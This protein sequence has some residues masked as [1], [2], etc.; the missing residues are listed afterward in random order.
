VA[1]IVLVS[2]NPETTG[3]ALTSANET[4]AT[5]E[6][7]RA[8]RRLAGPVVAGASGKGWRITSIDQRDLIK[9]NR[10][11]ILPAAV[12]ECL[13][14]L[15]DLGMPRVGELFDVKQ[16]ILTGMNDAFI[17]SR[18]QLE[19]LPESERRFFRPALFRNAIS[20]GRIH[21]RHYVFFPYDFAGPLF[22]DEEDVRT[23]V[24]E[25]FGHYLEPRE[26]QLR[27]RSG[28]D[29]AAKPWWLLSRYYK[30]VERSEARILTKYFGTVGDFVVDEN[31]RYVP[32]H[33][34]AWFFRGNRGRS[35][36]IDGALV[37]ILRAYY[38]LLNSPTFARLLKVF[39]DPVAG[40]QFNLSVRFVRPIRIINWRLPRTAFSDR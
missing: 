4:T 32:L 23:Q 28:V 15:D 12:E 3:V 40:G 37:Q 27:K 1:A 29:D 35:L 13:A 6:A 25:Y 17:L 30:W 11:R 8:L 18:Q 26:A 16:G 14:R 5:G 36:A 21:D 10:W 38:S 34:Y 9:T 7:L 2:G 22:K 39:S 20:D 24:P 31:A 19:M 33:G